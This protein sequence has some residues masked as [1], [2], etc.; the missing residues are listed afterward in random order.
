PL[1]PVSSLAALAAGATDR[2]FGASPVVLAVLDARRSEYY[3]ATVRGDSVTGS[4]VGEVGDSG[5]VA[6]I[7]AELVAAGTP[8]VVV[9]DGAVK[10]IAELRETGAV[11]PAADDPNHVIDA[12]LL[13]ELAREIAPAAVETVVPDYVRAP[14]AKI[15][16]R[17]SWLVATAGA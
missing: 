12:R 3:F 7:A 6:T 17:A 15:S 4:V 2:G 14:D 1:V 11:V 16:T 5:R 10:L 13:I 8:P 9:G